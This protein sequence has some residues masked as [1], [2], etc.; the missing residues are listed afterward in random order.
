MLAEGRKFGFRLRLANQ[1]A[2]Q[3]PAQ[4]WETALANTGAVVVY[5]TGPKDATLLD[6]VFPS[7]PTLTF[8]QLPKYW[9]AIAADGQDQVVQT[10]P[11]LDTD[12]DE[13][14]IQ[15]GHQAALAGARRPHLQRLASALAACCETRAGEGGLLREKAHRAAAGAIR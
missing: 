3:I 4:L 5:R 7:V 8:T 10:L 12:I 9:A 11:P 1:N 6:P 15:R 14:A 13:T 2:A